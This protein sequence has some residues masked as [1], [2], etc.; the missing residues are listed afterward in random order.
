MKMENTIKKTEIRFG[1]YSSL[2]LT[3]I[4]VITFGFAMIAVPI[5]GAFCPEGC[6]EYPYLDTL[7]QFPKDFIWMYFA[8]LLIIVYLAFMVSIHYYAA[9][10]KKLFS[11]TGILFSVISA[12]VLLAAYFIQSSAIPASLLNRETEGI[13][14]LIQYNP[15]GV[16]IALEEL[17]YIMM[18]FSFLFVAPVF[19]NKSRIEKSIRWIFIIA[20]VLTVLSFVLVS[21]QHGVVRMDRF[22][23][24]VISI[25]WLVLIINGIL[26]SMVFKRILKQNKNR[27][28]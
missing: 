1:F 5:S 22:E 4:T 3:I 26:I 8:M 6:V 24:F 7:K 10:E 28:D 18:S 15:H 19:A 16:F 14:M 17:G 21:V 9:N 12:V 27:E 13:P 11:Q 20:F 23:V 2:F 25:D